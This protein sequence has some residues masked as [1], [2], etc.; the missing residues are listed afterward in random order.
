MV[1]LVKT[2][3]TLRGVNQSDLSKDTGVSVTTIS[4]FL[5]GSTELKS[6]ALLK[7]LSSLGTDVNSIVKS[8]INKALG[9]ADDLSI[10]DDIRYLMEQASPIA[11][12][13]IAETIIS[14]FKNDKSTDTKNR[15]LRI[16]KYKDSIKTVRRL[17]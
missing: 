1:T 11:R 10:G 17:S 12:K 16:K 3:M 4:R 2:L 7:I 6:E 14:S 5:T 9:N 8:E 13:T 15:I